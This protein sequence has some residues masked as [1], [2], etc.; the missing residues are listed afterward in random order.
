MRC[1][2]DWPEDPGGTGPNHISHK[3][4]IFDEMHTDCDWFLM[5]KAGL[6]RSKSRRSAR[7][8]CPKPKLSPVPPV[9]SGADQARFSPQ[10][11]GCI[12]CFL[13]PNNSHCSTS[14]AHPAPRI[15]ALPKFMRHEHY[16]NFSVANSTTSVCGGPDK[17][18][19]HSMANDPRREGQGQV[20]AK[21]LRSPACVWR[22]SYIIPPISRVTQPGSPEVQS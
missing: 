20:G 17:V 18:L 14:S 6:P 8:V 16:G 12:R 13:Q 19:Q 7:P 9:L 3:R 5:E 4:L 10:L 1:W 15:G 21:G 22:D 2:V 11:S